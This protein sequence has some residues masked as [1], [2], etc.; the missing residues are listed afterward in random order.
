MYGFGFSGGVLRQAEIGPAT[1]TEGS[2]IVW[3]IPDANSTVCHGD[4]GAPVVQGNVAVGV[5]EDG[6][7]GKDGHC[8]AIATGTMATAPAFG[9]LQQNGPG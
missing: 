2:R 4:S 1:S 5:I 7:D 9:W 6:D 8:A 3:A